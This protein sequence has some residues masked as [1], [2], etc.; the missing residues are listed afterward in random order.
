MAISSGTDLL[1]SFYPHYILV[2]FCALVAG[3]VVL[4]V[5]SYLRLRHIPGPILASFSNLP[6]LSWV[7]SKRSQHVHQK[8]HAKYGPVVRLGPNAVSIGDP[9]AIP[10]IYTFTGKFA[11]SNYYSVLT[12]YS[13]GKAIPMMFATQD[14]AIHRMLRKPVAGIYSMSNMV[15][16]ERFVDSTMDV[17]FKELD[18]R[19]IAKSE[20]CDFSVW[21][22]RFAFDV[23]GEITF[24]KR[25][26]FL[27]EP[28]KVG[29]LMHF[30]WLH[31]RY[32]SMV[33]ALLAKEIENHCIFHNPSRRH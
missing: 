13:K 8:L 12:P 30:I 18:A 11:K 4:S 23:M 22:Q 14:E 9:E 1:A 3:Y 29:D 16:F 33:S 10:D 32:A 2:L 15:G 19:F 27:E 26:G 7:V 20:P 31:F 21:L 28:E 6:R 17:F 24:S 5:Q 25:L